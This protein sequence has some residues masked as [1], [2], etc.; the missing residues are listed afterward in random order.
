MKMLFI[1]VLSISTLH[2]FP[3]GTCFTRPPFA[4]IQKATDSGNI[5][6]ADVEQYIDSY[7]GCE[8][9]TFNVSTIKGK[10]IW[11]EGLKGKVVF[12][13]FWYTS[14]GACVRQF[15]SLNKLAAE[16]AGRVEFITFAL[17]TKSKLDSFLLLH[18]LDLDVVAQSGALMDSFQ[19]PFCPFSFIL[20]KDNRVVKILHSDLRKQ[21]YEFEDYDRAKPYIEAALAKK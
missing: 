8:V 2:I 5:W 17:D 19:V 12:I 7:T 21:R 16:Y 11:L 9:P 14:C 20:D 13:D 15:K 3:Q 6:R 4:Y 1:F 18:P 10:K